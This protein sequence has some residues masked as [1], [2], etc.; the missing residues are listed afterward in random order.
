MRPDTG[1]RKRTDKF[2]L[3][4]PH[5]GC[6]AAHVNPPSHFGYTHSSV[7]NM[8]RSSI[9]SSRRSFRVVMTVVLRRCRPRRR[10]RS[11]AHL[12]R[13]S[14]FVV[15]ALGDMSHGIVCSPTQTSHVWN[16]MLM[17]CRHGD[18]CL[19]STAALREVHRFA[20]HSIYV[21]NGTHGWMWAGAQ[22]STLVLGSATVGKDIVP[23]HPQYF[24]VRRSGRLD[25]DQARRH[26]GDRVLARSATDGRFSTTRAV[27]SNA[28]PASNASAGRRSPTASDWDA[29]V[30]TADAMVGASR[31]S[32][33]A[34]AS[35]TG[36]SGPARCSRRCSTPP[37]SRSSP[38]ATSSVDR[39]PQRGPGPRNS[40][41]ERRARTLRRRICWPGSSPRIPVSSQAS[42]P[43]RRACWPRTARRAR[44]RRRA[45]PPLD[46]EEFCGGAEHALRL[47]DRSA[48]APIRPARRRR[49]RRRA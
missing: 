37:P 31:L 44:S 26:A 9:L 34:P 22:R 47:L 13:D 29:A 28:R 8:L 40:R 30:V 1:A 38:C 42:G 23:G 5:S 21:G 24:A 2:R 49:R 27:K 48:A 12:R 43:P 46:L 45:P 7:V 33:R 16:A 17:A 20:R 3:S 4:A 6:V 36:P 14:V 32:G 39:S 10:T 11:T 35:I 18:S 15:A 19:I 41:L 25:L